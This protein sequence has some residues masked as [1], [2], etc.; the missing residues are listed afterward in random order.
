MGVRGW[1]RGWGLKVRVRVGGLRVEGFGLRVGGLGVR[2][3]EG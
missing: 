1:G 3:R 2:V